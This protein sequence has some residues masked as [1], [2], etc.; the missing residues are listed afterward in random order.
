MSGPGR[1]G[2]CSRCSLNA[3]LAPRG[4]YNESVALNTEVRVTAENAADL[5]EDRRMA[6]FAELVAA[7][8][9][10]SSVQASRE[11]VAGRHGVSVYT[12][13]QIEREGLDAGWP[14]L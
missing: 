9:E 7:Q 6:I 1:Q 12:V 4:P 2:E 10:G 8:D 13:L 5:P 3:T 14:P 11:A